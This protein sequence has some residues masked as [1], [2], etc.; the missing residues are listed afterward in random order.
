MDERYRDIYRRLYRRPYRFRW[1]EPWWPP[2]GPESFFYELVKIIDDSCEKGDS[3]IPV[4]EDA[5]YFLAINLYH[6]ILVPVMM[7][8]QSEPFPFPED[9]FDILRSDCDL[10]INASRSESSAEEITGGA[11]LSTCARVYTQLKG[12]AQNI[13]G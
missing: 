2:F 3:K 13:W 10:I 12:A 5:R 7:R 6:M 11:M 4:R 9:I 8:D 1:P